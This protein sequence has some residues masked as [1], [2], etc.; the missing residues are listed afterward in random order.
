[1]KL[2]ILLVL[3]TINISYAQE[4]NLSDD[5][6]D[7]N[8]N[9]MMRGSRPQLREEINVVAHSKI[10]QQYFYAHFYSSSLVK[11]F[12][13]LLDMIVTFNS[14]DNILESK[15]YSKL[16]SA[17]SYIEEKEE[18]LGHDLKDHRPKELVSHLYVQDEKIYNDVINEI[19]LNADKLFDQQSELKAKFKSIIIPSINRNGNFTGRKFPKDVWALTYDDGP[20]RVTT[21]K[22]VD[23]LYLNN[24][25]ATFFMQTKNAKAFVDVAQYVIDSGMEIGLH[26]YTHKN[27]RKAKDKILNYEITQAKKDIESL[28]NVDI[29]L[30]RLP[31]GAGMR[32][33]KVRQKI[34]DNKMIHVFWDV[35]T[36]DWKDKSSKSILKRTLKQMKLRKNKGGIILYH[37]I[38]PQTVKTTKLLID[39]FI[40]NNLKTCT[41]GQMIKLQNGEPNDCLKEE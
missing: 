36:L 40:K 39:H 18:V 11:E 4:P 17:R 9:K 28:L 15:V 7:L 25:Q 14:D 38:Q 31:Y 10:E 37:D 13:K 16:I 8:N 5:T 41:I 27:L 34:A 2:I 22:I 29:Q 1:M 3:T 24:M 32:V 23:D 35:D 20:K 6:R 30:F 12:D 33:E 19:N 26:S 21:Q